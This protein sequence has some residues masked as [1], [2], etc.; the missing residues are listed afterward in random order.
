MSVATLEDSMEVPQKVKNRLV[1][2]LT[3]VILAI[4][5]IEIMRIAVQ[6]Q[7]GKN[8]SNSPPYESINHI[9]W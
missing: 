9:W 1:R 2:W 4:E 3:H 8:I 6:D 5:V 7:L